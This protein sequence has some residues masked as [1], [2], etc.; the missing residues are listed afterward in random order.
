MMTTVSLVNLHQHSYIFSFFFFC[1]FAISWAAPKA[2]GGSQAK[3]PIRAIATGLRHRHSNT[4]FEPHLQPT[5][6]LTTTP[7]P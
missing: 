5:P 6:Q 2:Y 1:L 3:G 4:R 7:V